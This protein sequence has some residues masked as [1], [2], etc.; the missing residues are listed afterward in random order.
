MKCLET[1]SFV[2]KHLI[3]LV[4]NEFW[5]ET[6]VDNDV[7]YEICLVS[8]WFSLQIDLVFWTSRP[9]SFDCK[10]PRELKW[11]K[12]YFKRNFLGLF[13]YW[14]R[15]LGFWIFHASLKVIFF[16]F[17]VKIVSENRYFT[18]K[19][20]LGSWKLFSRCL[21]DYLRSNYLLLFKYQSNRII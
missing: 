10:N 8:M 20:L 19:I 4:R 14:P 6:R 2:G 3:R 5:M 13:F 12:K 9:L 11:K 21:F 16:R 18:I 7:D 15:P 17:S 1:R